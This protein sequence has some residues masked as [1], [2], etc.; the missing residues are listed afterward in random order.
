MKVFFIN[1]KKVGV[2][3]LIVVLMISLFWMGNFLDKGNQITQN[4]YTEK[5]LELENIDFN[6]FDALDGSVIYY[7]PSD[8]IVEEKDFGSKEIIY[9]NNFKTENS[10]INGFIQVWQLKSNIEE[11]LESSKEISE[12][13]NDIKDYSLIPTRI[14]GKKA[15]IL[16][17]KIKV[18]NNIYYRTY[19]YY[20]E[21]NENTI[22]FAFYTK[23][24]D[25]TGDYIELLNNIVNKIE[26]K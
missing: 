21:N 26:L 18:I 2:T 25:L 10:E 4:T 24:D 12:K 22:R 3:T 23:E 14:K 13:Q 1:A 8:W 20:I 15:Y 11:F 7:L 19:E 5:E 9:H 16:S 6:K 17:Y